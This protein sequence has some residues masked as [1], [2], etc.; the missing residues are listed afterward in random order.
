METQQLQ[1]LISNLESVDSSVLDETKQVLIEHGHEKE[2]LDEFLSILHYGSQRKKVQLVDILSDIHNESSFKLLMYA[3]HDTHRQVRDK[4]IDN[5]KKREDPENELWFVEAH[6]SYKESSDTDA[7][8]QALSSIKEY[9][10]NE[11][12]KYF[13]SH[14]KKY[15]SDNPNIDLTVRGNLLSVLA[16]HDALD[17][18]ENL[19]DLLDAVKYGDWDAKDYAIKKLD[20]II[21]STTRKIYCALSDALVQ[22]DNPD[23][24][25][26]LVKA[27][28][29]E[30][31]NENVFSSI[32]YSSNWFAK[33]ILYF[34]NL[35]FYQDDATL[36]DDELINKIKESQNHSWLDRTALLLI[37]AEDKKRIWYCD[38][39][40]YY[41]QQYVKLLKEWGNI[42]CGEFLPEN[43]TEAK[44][45]KG[46]KILIKFT[47][48]QQQIE[49]LADDYGDWLDIGIFEEINELIKDSKRQFW[50]IVTGSQELCLICLTA[51]EKGS[52]EKDLGLRFELFGCYISPPK[53][54]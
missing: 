23:I 28:Y 40:I 33:I 31:T 6:L 21:D 16:H 14:I 27:L 30:N 26:Y 37:L 35:G 43:I 51:D 46:E 36:T 48:K 47:H 20:K 41:S 4:V 34:R 24:H 5:L 49:I 15:L 32:R 45:K 11:K 52:L 42:S 53:L 10:K 13:I 9:R 17:T 19:T 50:N 8:E 3:Q 22:E 25:S 39:E 7:R 2:V 18:A 12:R 29:P 1:K 44:N 38:S 54:S